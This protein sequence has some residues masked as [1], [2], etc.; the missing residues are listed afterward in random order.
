MKLKVKVAIVLNPEEA[1]LSLHMMEGY[2]AMK[3]KVLPTQE[4]DFLQ[5]YRELRGKAEEAFHAAGK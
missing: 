4:Q 5:E 2:A 3:Q 1:A